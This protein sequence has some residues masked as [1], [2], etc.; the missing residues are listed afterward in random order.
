MESFFERQK[1]EDP[2]STLGSFRQVLNATRDSQEFKDFTH[3]YR[4]FIRQHNATPGA[5]NRRF[6]L[7]LQVR[8]IFKKFF[9]QEA[10][11]AHT[12]DKTAEIL[13]LFLWGNL[14]SSAHG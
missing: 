4:E 11:K 5:P 12:P 7:E 13:P 6:S 10:E 1:L 2:S 9:K 3:R 8:R 14:I